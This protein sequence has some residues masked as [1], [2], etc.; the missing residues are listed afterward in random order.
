MTPTMSLVSKN[1]RGFQ[2]FLGSLAGDK[3]VFTLLLYPEV[4]P[5]L[6]L[7]Q[8]KTETKDIMPENTAGISTKS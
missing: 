8:P 2:L 3:S 5:Q 7:C 4:T 6:F 1:Y